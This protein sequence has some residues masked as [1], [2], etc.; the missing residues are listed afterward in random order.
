M[1]R[2]NRKK[3]ILFLIITAA[4]F[5]FASCNNLETATGEQPPE[6]QTATVVVGGYTG[7]SGFEQACY[8]WGA[9]GGTLEKVI[10]HD[11][12]W[13]S[14]LVKNIAISGS[15]IYASGYYN[16]GTNTLPCYWV[17][18]AD[19]RVDLTVPPATTS[20]SAYR[21]FV[22]GGNIYAMGY[23]NDGVYHDCY[24]IN[25]TRTDIDTATPGTQINVYNWFLYENTIYAS[26][27]CTT[28]QVSYSV[29]GD[30]QYWMNPSVDGEASV[31]FV[32]NDG[33]HLIGYD[34]TNS[35]YQYWLNGIADVSAAFGTTNMG[36]GGN[37]YAN[38]LF[39]SGDSLYVAGEN[40]SS[41]QACY[42]ENGTLVDLGYETNLSSAYSIHYF[43]GH[44]YTCGWDGPSGSYL[45]CYWIDNGAPQY[46]DIED[47]HAYSIWDPH[48]DKK[49][50]S[51]LFIKNL[52]K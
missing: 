8:W 31:I 41:S 4:F 39:V 26:G 1:K 6:R 2:L 27:S 21:I 7:T 32:N 44:V 47:G 20:A 9:P 3:L 42:W 37:H 28:G 22:S 29:I 16:D 24:W 17:M 18:N 14:S 33:V 43:E 52:N 38:D 51:E 45:P 46:L 23:Y 50:N 34:I 35:Q 13:S 12:E 49:F 10:L 30:T 48:M 36:S 5:T 19:D 15:T 40:W 11:T 25:G